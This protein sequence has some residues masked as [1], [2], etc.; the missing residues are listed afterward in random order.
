MKNLALISITF[1][2]FLITNMYGSASTETSTG[3]THCIWDAWFKY[4]SQNKSFPY[5]SDV[6]VRVDPKKYHDIA[7]MELFI[8]GKY[9]RKESH[10]PYEWAK[11]NSN[12][13]HLLRNMNPGTYKLKVKIKDK[14]GHVHYKHRTFYI[15]PHEGPNLCHFTNPLIDLS[16]LKHIKNK[17]PNYVICEYKKNGKTY[18]K[19]YPC[20]QNH[21]TIYWYNCHGTKVAQVHSSHPT[22]HIVKG[23]HKIK[24]WWKPCNSGNQCEWQ[25]W[26]KYPQQNASYPKGADIYVRV[27]TKKHQDIEYIQLYING[28]YVRKES[29]YPYEWAKG[30]GNSDH[31]LRDMHPGNYTLV[32]KIKDKCGKFHE[33]KT[34]FHVKHP[35]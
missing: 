24:C 17:Y 11:S 35:Q 25:S 7:Y 8:N 5:G 13:D 15:T 12:G 21:C 22:P 1:F 4:P 14:C 30:S 28:K 19:I 26:F 27:D 31:Y 23:A 3:F 29:Y 18:F 6:Y 10:Y 2:A 20:G 34:H 16:W 33:I 9:I 32:A